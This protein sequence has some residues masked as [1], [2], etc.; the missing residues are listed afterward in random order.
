MWSAPL[1]ASKT[2]L[3]SKSISIKNLLF[4]WCIFFWYLYLIR[5]NF[6]SPKHRVAPSF[7]S[8]FKR[9]SERDRE[10]EREREREIEW[11]CDC[12]PGAGSQTPGRL[13]LLP[14]HKTS[15]ESSTQHCS[16]KLI[17]TNLN[18]QTLNDL[19]SKIC[20]S[21]S[22]WQL[23]YQNFTYI[24]GTLNRQI[25]KTSNSSSRTTYKPRE[26]GITDHTKVYSSSKN[27]T[28]SI[29]LKNTL[30]TRTCKHTNLEN[31]QRSYKGIFN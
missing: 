14:S 7:W 19:G 12:I 20:R 24:V 17:S 13:A 1:R 5:M 30:Y 16:G 26:L 10:R 21:L 4:T 11:R 18:K 25:T 15:R 31:Y 22:E 9:E 2:S 27:F 28:Y 23:T 3:W 29:I 6:S 8:K